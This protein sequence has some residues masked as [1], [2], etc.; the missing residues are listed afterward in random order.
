MILIPTSN[1]LPTFLEDVV[2]DALQI[3][4]YSESDVFVSD[5]YIIS[6]KQIILNHLIWHIIA[7]LW[8]YFYVMLV[9]GLTHG[10]HTLG[11]K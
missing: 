9:I 3:G 2:G 6:L 5:V 1:I 4:V 11:V 7:Y 10:F 8:H